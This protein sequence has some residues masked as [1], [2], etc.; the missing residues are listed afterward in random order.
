MAKLYFN[1]A[2]MN[3]GKSTTLL[4]ASF[5]YRER[6][7]NTIEFTA[8][9]DNRFETGAIASRIG[10]QKDA[11]LFDSKTDIFAIV[12]KEINEKKIACIFLD[13]AQFLTGKQ[14][15]ELSKIV[16][17]LNIP[18]ICYGLRT[19]FR[20]ELFEGSGRLL[21]LAD[22]IR[23]LKT[24]CQCGRKATM[25][26]RINPDGEAVKTGESI[27]IGGNERYAPLCRKHFFK[28]L[29]DAV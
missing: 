16:D 23:E 9:I 28:A 27:E 5:N 6:G 10:L 18:V 20:G 24:I 26:L 2:A 29:R 1:Y 17:E 4:Q 8:K 25:N 7:L 19:D 13:E 21:A 14:V 22:E 11:H 15:L 12:K 3:A